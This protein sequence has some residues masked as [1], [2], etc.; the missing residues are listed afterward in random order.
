VLAL[1]LLT[2]A[3]I[4]ITARSHFHQQ[5]RQRFDHQA[6]R[7]TESV[8]RRISD[9][10]MV[11]RGTE[12]LFSVNASVTR[13]QWRDY[14]E[15]L[16]VDAWLNG[17]VGVGFV[18]VVPAEKKEEFLRNTR[19]DGAPDY[20]IRPS[21]ER[22]DY[23]PI[24]YIE[25][26]FRNLPRLGFDIGSEPI[27]R[28][29]AERARDTG[30]SAITGKVILPQDPSTEAAVVL[31]QPM[32]R[33]GVRPV[34]MEDRRAAFQGWSQIPIRMNEL[35][36]GILDDGLAEIDFHIYD[37]QEENNAA[38]LFDND[39]HLDTTKPVEKPPFSRQTTLTI[40]G[41]VWTLRFTSKPRF[42]Q[43][44]EVAAP[45]GILVS[46]VLASLLLAG[47][48]WSSGSTRARAHDLAE[49]MTAELRQSTVETE[50]ALEE[51]SQQK[52]AL[53]QHAIVA[54]TDTAGRITYVNDKFCWISKYG[55]DEMLGQ[56][57]R[58][59]NSGHHPKEFFKE[60]YR[61]IGRGNVW[62]GQICN[63]AKD[64]SIYWV[65]TTIVPMKD[66]NGKPVA[67]VAIRM[68]I[69]RQKESE[70]RIHALNADLVQRADALVRANEQLQE[71]DRLK[72][73]FLANMSHEI[74]T[75]MN[76]I[77][78][79]TGL[80]LGTPLN[81]KQEHYARTVQ[82]SADALLAIINDILDFSKMEAGKLVFETIDFQLR[83]AVE[84]V[85]ESLAEQ[86]SRK[87]LELACHIHA[88]VPDALVGD[89]GRLRQALS[90]LV[91][92]G[93]KFTHAGS[94]AIRVALE[95]ETDSHAILRF[96]IEDTGIGIDPAAHHRLFEP[97]SQADVSTT[98]KYGGSGLGL[99]ISK[100]LIGR[101]GGEIGVESAAGK[102]TTFWFTARFQKQPPGAVKP[103][104][105][106]SLEGLRVLIVDD[107]QVNRTILEHQV[108]D[109][110]MNP[111][112]AAN[113][114][115][116]CAF[117]RQAASDGAPF[118]LVILDMQMPGMNGLEVARRIKAD[119]STANTTLLILTSI[120]D[121]LDEATLRSTGISACLT[122]PVMQ[123]H[124]RTRIL[125]ALSREGIPVSSAAAQT[126]A[127]GAKLDSIPGRLKILVAE[128]NQV[129][130]EI[131]LGQLERLGY[132]ADIASNGREAIEAHARNH[133]D[134][135]LM[136]CQMPEMDG[137]DATRHLRAEESASAQSHQP[138]PRVRI[139]ALTAHAMRGDREKC[140][141]A[142]MDD[143][144][145]KPVQI[146]ELKAALALCEPGEG[147]AI[148]HSTPSDGLSPATSN[149]AAPASE[150][151]PPLV[152][153]PRLL[154]VAMDDP[155]QI[156]KLTGIFFKDA[157]EQM[158]KLG[159]AITEGNID[160]VRR[161]S[162]KTG[163]GAISLG[164]AA[165]AAPLRAIEAEAEEGCLT[166]ADTLYQSASELFAA[167]CEFIADADS[168]GFPTEDAPAEE[169]PFVDFERL[170]EISLD[171]PKRLAKLTATYFAE[172]RKHLNELHA[173]IRS[174]ETETVRRL[175]HKCRGSSLS[176]GMNAVATPLDALE[177]DP[178]SPEAAIASL[179]EATENLEKSQALLEARF[180]P[181]T[182]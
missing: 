132:A 122:K 158:Q 179:H 119:P 100:E 127:R 49:R 95:S 47:V 36:K 120:G 96:R 64:G 77:I 94:V 79:M 9:C 165:L 81:G 46:G 26:A 128:D 133:Y 121:Q 68:D 29:A 53:D 32:Y 55:R 11:L 74:R 173:A 89:S 125:T 144:V 41:R 140:L 113:G 58:M 163:G 130:Q 35:M 50:R 17:A 15:R 105:T 31:L 175:A 111:V 131:A 164:F 161:L 93:I 54:V 157:G 143:Y 110:K 153:M 85:A 7:V 66:A 117:L 178:A 166:Q 25:P 147:V 97:F 146:K 30:L 19:A 44:G 6:E 169:E 136:D 172:T 162:H 80:L 10:E 142:G 42:I 1:S 107:N 51:L 8:I 24:Q 20:Q 135:I 138:L 88:S 126:P 176:M 181:Q 4:W 101:M 180:R 91:N 16:K 75:P 112:S 13:Q 134:V 84:G 98:R 21:G 171:D 72:S 70:A 83:E 69:T 39:E 52:F 141:A 87:S 145:T 3:V 73:A 167:T 45:V 174:G 57:H 109:W 149:E 22:P 37:G 27:R 63:K 12:G 150:P 76:G 123:S 104:V 103:A 71:M 116:A 124:L 129:N 56:D 38:L 118:P 34:T 23:F 5:A 156:R 155:D 154:D 152:D 60:M 151:A 160:Q 90:N 48:A 108:S 2:T 67:Y 148:H 59:L 114:W 14:L 159:Q 177:R 28:A 18:A 182:A 61:T 86:A 99:V 139:I 168:R 40:A 137:Y 78:G 43:A 170:Q 92:N 102:G 33:H 82:S 115:E 106:T 62:H 65:D